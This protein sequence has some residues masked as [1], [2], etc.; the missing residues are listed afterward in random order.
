M[1]DQ[2][3][4]GDSE[5]GQFL[6]K[7]AVE[8]R[9]WRSQ[10]LISQEQATAILDSYGADA[11]V[12]AVD[13]AR[14]RLISILAVLGAILVG[15]GIILFLAAN[16]D[17]ILRPIRLALVM[18]CVPATYGAAFW[19]RYV[20]GYER[21]GSAFIL[22]AAIVYGAAIHL[23]AQ[24]YNFPLNDPTLFT[25]WL[26]GV[27][28]IAYLTRSQPAVFLTIGLGLGATS[29]WLYEY[30]GDSGSQADGIFSISVFAMLGLGLYGLGRL[31]GTFRETIDY[32]WA[33]QI[34]GTL[35]VL[36]T[37]YLLGFRSVYE[38][39]ASAERIDPGA[40]IGLW[41]LLCVFAAIGLMALV[42]VCVKSLSQ[43]RT[44]K[45][46]S[47]ELLASILVAA[48]VFTVL[49]APHGHE[50]TFPL[51]FN[52]LLVAA[53]IGLV[54]LGYVRAM[55]SFIN[56]GL[57]FFALDVVTRYFELSWDLLDRSIVFIVAGVILLAG[58]FFLERGRRKV[59]ERMTSRERDSIEG[60]H[61]P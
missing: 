17:A 25:Y 8:V 57:A 2:P 24:I 55:E 21:V 47:F 12:V 7:L 20:K 54:V 45:T 30:L 39:M 44:V 23:V 11:R 38:G 15:V 9:R 13:K 32:A 61:E 4:M 53:I 31:Q 1:R 33:F 34:M 36:F 3:T 18:A 29:F 22:L 46:L 52:L 50:I 28:P 14:G 42:V 56:I 26:A 40:P 58:G 43:G 35:T 48:A 19:L 6:A 37:V 10:G 41:A 5:D 59:F 27:A 16:W 49:F 51:V 60:V